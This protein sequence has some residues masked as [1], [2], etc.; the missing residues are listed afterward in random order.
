MVSFPREEKK[1]KSLA[2]LV[3][4][5]LED[6]G[7]ERADKTNL[8]KSTGQRSCIA[9]TFAMNRQWEETGRGIQF[10]PTHTG[11]RWAQESSPTFKAAALEP[12]DYKDVLLLFRVVQTSQQ[13]TYTRCKSD[14]KPKELVCCLSRPRP[15]A[16]LE[17]LTGSPGEPGTP[18]V[19]L[20]GSSCHSFLCSGV[21]SFNLLVPIPPSH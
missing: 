15:G 8:K 3:V 9:E 12:T 6:S 21:C 13:K 2:L 18:P 20:N 4:Q 16:D 10:A 11:R 17:A 19:S 5:T 7:R 14:L 1:H